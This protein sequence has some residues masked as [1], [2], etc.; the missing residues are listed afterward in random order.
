[1]N[2]TFSKNLSR[3]PLREDEAVIFRDRKE[4]EYLKRLRTGREISIRN[5]RIPVEDLI[6]REEGSLVRSS[7]NEPF[8][9]LRPTMA[10]LIPSLPRKAQVI[11]PKDIALILIWADIF[12]GAKVVEAD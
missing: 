7:M 9:V 5:G 4:R 2:D 1:M 3:G 11:Y 8:L 12:P 6:G 10:Q